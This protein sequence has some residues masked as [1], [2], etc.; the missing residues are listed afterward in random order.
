[1]RSKG[2]Y[3]EPSRREKHDGVIT[4][5]LSLLVQKLFAK[6]DMRQNPDLTAGDLDIDL[7][8]KM[9]E[10][11]WFGILTSNRMPFTA[12]LSLLVSETDGGG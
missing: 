5:S 6:N 7:S 4:D 3:F 12:S 11:T 10:V 9:T 1:M 2:I 8:E